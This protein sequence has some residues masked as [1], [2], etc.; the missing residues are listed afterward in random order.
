[1]DLADWGNKLAGVVARLAG[2]LHL[3]AQAETTTT[4]WSTPIPPEIMSHAIRLGDY[5]AAHARA[6]YWRMGVGER[7]ADARYVL[8]VF[9]VHQWG[10]VGHRDLWRSVRRRIASTE[11]L[12]AV[13]GYL[14]ELGYLRIGANIGSCGN[15]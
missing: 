6:A 12:S 10:T 14:A 13:C 2:L 15:W 1:M 7:D 3:L 4:P 11:A 9:R 5:F 8:A